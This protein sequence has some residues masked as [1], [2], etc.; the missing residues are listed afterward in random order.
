LKNRMRNVLI[1]HFCWRC[2]RATPP[3]VT[4]GISP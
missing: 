3:A 1:G 2:K 4:G